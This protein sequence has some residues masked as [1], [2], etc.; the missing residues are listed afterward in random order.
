MSSSLSLPG[1]GARGLVG[2]SR[3]GGRGGFRALASAEEG[4]HL[5]EGSD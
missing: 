2:G 4:A 1:H 3:R 5:E